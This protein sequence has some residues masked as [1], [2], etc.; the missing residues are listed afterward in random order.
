MGV[1]GVAGNVAGVVALADQPAA[2]KPLS[3]DAWAA[4]ALQHPAAS[5]TSAVAFVLGLLALAAWARALAVAGSG[6]SRLATRS[7]TAGAL[8]NALGCVAPLVLVLHVA[9]GCTAD[10]CGP[11]AR[12]LLGLTLT[13][14]ATFNLLLG[15]GLALLGGV[16]LRRG[17]RA[18]GALG[19]LAGLASLP[20]S[21]QVVSPA[22][23]NLLAVAAPLWLAFV[24]ATSVRLWRAPPASPAA[25]AGRTP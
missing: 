15:A 7:I 23:A 11:V 25:P 3:L 17:A 14:D 5:V 1:L 6:A 18:L 8:F 21:L 19:L 24:L 16:L 12:A 20:V 13:L 4:Q 2:Y 22:A 10:G 9:P